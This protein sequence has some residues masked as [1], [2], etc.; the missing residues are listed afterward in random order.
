MN[1][2][3]AEVV[4]GLNDVSMIAAGA[5]FSVALKADGTVWVFGSN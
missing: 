3:R 1:R 4:P 5:L 2:A